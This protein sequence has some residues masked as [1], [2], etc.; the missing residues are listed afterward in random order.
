L[1]LTG[2]SRGKPAGRFP[3]ALLK[4]YI[5]GYLNRVQSSLRLEREAGRNVEVM[6]LTGRLAPDHKTIAGFRK[7]LKDQELIR[8]INSP[9]NGRSDPQGLQPVRCALPPN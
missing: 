1:A 2:S 9:E 5:Y 7:G 6:W 8:G 3:A 4:L